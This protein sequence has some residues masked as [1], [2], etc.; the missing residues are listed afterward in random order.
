[1]K[2]LTTL[3]AA[4]FLTVGISGNAMAYFGSPAPTVKDGQI[5]AGIFLSDSMI[6]FLG[7]FA[8]SN[9]GLLHL[10]Y[11]D[12]SGKQ[13]FGGGKVSYHA[14][15]LGFGYRH[16]AGKVTN[17]RGKAL[18]AGGF[19]LYR[20]GNIDKVNTASYDYGYSIINLGGG[21]ALEVTK[22][23]D[24]YGG[25]AYNRHADEFETDSRFGFYGGVEFGLSPVMQLGAELQSGFGPGSDTFFLAAGMKF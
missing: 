11:H 7:D 5:S 24:L 23:L 10:R 16:S 3:F 1:M 8:I 21:V 14:T 6:G 13:D 19:F 12:I 4:L 2:K 18:K 15:E 20:S 17:M 9:E 22:S 25:L